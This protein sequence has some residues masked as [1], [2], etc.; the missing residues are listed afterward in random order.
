MLSLLVIACAPDATPA[1]QTELKLTVTFARKDIDELRIS[2]TALARNRNFGPFDSTN[3]NIASGCTISLLFDATDDGSTKVCIEGRAS[4]AVA[5]NACGMFEVQANA[6]RTGTLDLQ[7]VA[8]PP[9]PTACQ[10]LDACCH[11]LPGDQQ[12]GCEAIVLVGDLS[13]CAARLASLEQANV[14]R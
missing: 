14:C 12:A 9:D 1:A 3:S 13:V 6:L 10:N 5:A 4:G 8:P 2:G 7:N 11:N